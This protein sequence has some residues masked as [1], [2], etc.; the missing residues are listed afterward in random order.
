MKKTS[1]EKTFDLLQETDTNWSVNKKQLISVDGFETA[2]FG[3]FRS[4]SNRWLATVGKKYTA[5]Q[6]ST[7][8]ETIVEAANRLGI[9]CFR[10]GY[11]GYGEKVYYQVCLEDAH[12]ATDTIKRYITAL[13]SHDGSTGIGFGSS[14]TVVVC[15]NTFYKAYKGLSKFIHTAKAEERVTVAMNNLVETIEQDKHQ[16]E[17]FSKF[18]DVKFTKQLQAEVIKSVFNIDMSK[19][20]AD[21]SKSDIKK[22][23]DF[24]QAIQKETARHGGDS[25]WS[26]FNAV[27][28]YTNHVEPY[29]SKGQLKRSVE[30]HVMVGEGFN[31]NDAAFETILRWVEENTHTPVLISK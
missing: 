21:V 20:T 16:I 24:D 22:L 2:S 4:D 3:M 6:N 9:D 1:Q 8:A 18:A 11:L 23:S 17:I 19:T 7:L 25:L 31:K 27:T 12:V 13:N 29:N 10:G 15:Q 30:Q 26:L 5:M 28:Y 14:S